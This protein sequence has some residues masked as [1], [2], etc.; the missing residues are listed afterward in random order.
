[1]KNKNKGGFSLLEIVIGLSFIV[2]VSITAIT[3][4]LASITAK[5]NTVNISRAQGF[6]DNVWECF[7]AADTQD[8]FFDLVEFSEG[9]NLKDHIADEREEGSYYL[10]EYKYTAEKYGYIA[11]IALETENE[12][13]EL[14]VNIID[15]NA[16]EIISLSYEKAVAL[17]KEG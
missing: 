15:L 17:K 6:A 9:V 16:E 14:K 3:I 4:T 5:V 2:I 8:E 11:Q 7:K 12:R 10:Y 1:M 13:T